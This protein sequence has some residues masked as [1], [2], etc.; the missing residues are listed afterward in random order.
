MCWNSTKKH[1]IQLYKQPSQRYRVGY[2]SILAA[3]G[4][5][6]FPLEMA[7]HRIII[8][9]SANP[10]MAIDIIDSAIACF[11]FPIGN[12]SA[13]ICTACRL[14]SPVGRQ[15]IIAL[16][17]AEAILRCGIIRCG[18]RTLS[19]CL[20]EIRVTLLRVWSE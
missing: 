2:R 6:L 1:L 7:R 3:M 16:V 13:Y 12:D 20:P 15:E 8:A 19:D 10:M 18:F 14:L 11:L 9:V 17:L 4:I 5:K